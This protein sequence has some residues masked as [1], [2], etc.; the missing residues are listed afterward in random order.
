[1]YNATFSVLTRATTDPADKSLLLMPFKPTNYMQSASIN[2][3]LIHGPPFSAL[4]KG[5]MNTFSTLS[6]KTNY[7]LTLPYVQ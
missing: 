4:E 1:M 2:W 6:T 3:F 7:F 5:V